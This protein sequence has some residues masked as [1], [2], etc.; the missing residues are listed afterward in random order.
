M[1]GKIVTIKSFQYYLECLHNALSKDRNPDILAE[2]FV[3]EL[4]RQSFSNYSIFSD[5]A[6]QPVSELADYFYECLT[7][8]KE[9]FSKNSTLALDEFNMMQFKIALRLIKYSCTI[10]DEIAR[11]ESRFSFA[12]PFSLMM[13]D[14]NLNP[15]DWKYLTE[16]QFKA[17]LKLSIGSDVVAR[18][19]PVTT[20]RHNGK[21]LSFDRRQASLPL[22]VVEENEYRESL[23]KLFERSELARKHAQKKR[24]FGTNYTLECLYHGGLAITSYNNT[25][26]CRNVYK[27]LNDYKGQSYGKNEIIVTIESIPRKTGMDVKLRVFFFLR[28]DWFGYMLNGY[29]ESESSSIDDSTILYTSG[30]PKKM[31]EEVLF[32][33]N[34]YYWATNGNPNQTPVDRALYNIT[35]HVYAKLINDEVK[36]VV[37][38]YIIIPQ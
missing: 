10:F 9:Q 1:K 3:Y 19:C 33:L 23:T 17:K 38:G 13:T 5:K 16:D 26:G 12:D 11:I 34:N 25:I 21:L 2:P 32:V 24:F 20:L 27:E 8:Y 6:D 14:N 35:M 28:I 18:I 22:L 29:I 36:P 7:Q 15:Q 30:I 4:M 37:P 31:V